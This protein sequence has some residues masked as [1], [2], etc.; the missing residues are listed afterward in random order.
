VFPTDEEAHKVAKGMGLVSYF[1][2]KNMGERPSGEANV[3]EKVKER[4]S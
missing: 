2:V 3:Y 1:D 4:V